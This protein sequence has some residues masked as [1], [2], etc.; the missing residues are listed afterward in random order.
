MTSRKNNET[1]LLP[2]VSEGD[3]AQQW[4]TIFSQGREHSLGGVQQSRSTNWT[5][6]DESAYLERVKERASAVAASIL[7]EARSEAARLQKAA[8]EEGYNAGIAAADAELNEFRSGMAESVAAVL[9]AIE[10]QCSQIFSMWR[11]DII[12]IARLAVEKV[13]AVELA[14]DR[15]QMLENLLLQAVALLEERR[16]LVIRVH[17]EDEPMLTDIVGLT[18]GKFPDVHV[19][20]IKADATINPGGMVL[21]SASSLAESRVESRRLAVEEILSHLILPENS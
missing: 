1:D 2:P 8:Q 5:P 18:Q 7:E 9:G 14:G 6:A 11:E 13:T 15:K 16:E 17:P 21:E 12:D 19:W 10:G 4:G 3:T 20:R